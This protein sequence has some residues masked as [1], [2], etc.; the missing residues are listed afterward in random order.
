MVCTARNARVGR[1]LCAFA[2][3]VVFMACASNACQVDQ[4]DQMDEIAAVCCEG[5]LAE[6]DVS[7]L[8]PPEC[9]DTMHGGSATCTAVLAVGTLSCPADYCPTCSMAGLCDATCG[10]CGG[11]HRRGQSLSDCSAGFPAICTRACAELLG[12]FW[13]SV[14]RT[15]FL[16]LQPQYRPPHNAVSI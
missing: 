12:P 14:C 4:L 15:M 6:T 10:Y 16:A 1:T 5:T 9:V 2:T 8:P 11:Q 7:Q 13:V 3:Q